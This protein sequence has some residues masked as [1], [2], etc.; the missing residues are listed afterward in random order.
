MKRRTK[1]T[2]II[3][4]LLFCC[5]LSFFFIWSPKTTTITAKPA[6]IV[7]P[8]SPEDIRIEEMH[9]KVFRQLGGY[10]GTEA[11]YAC[12]QKEYKDVSNSYHVHQGRITQDGNI[13]YDPSEAIDVGMGTRWYPFA[14]LDRTV[15]PETHW[16]LME[17]VFCAQCHPGGNVLTQYGMDVDCLIC[18][19]KSGYRGGQGLG[20]SLAGIDRDGN[21]MMSDGG[22][23]VA[24]MMDGAEAGGDMKKLDLSDIAIKAMEGV[25]LRIGKPGP[26][27]CNFCHWRTNSKRG[28][29]YGLFKGKTTDVHYAAGMRCQEC[30]VT[31]DHQI[32]KGKILDAI[33]TPELRGTM[34][35]CGDCHGEEPHMGEYADIMNYHFSRIACETCHIT[36]TYPSA[37]RLNW[38]PGMDIEGM[39][40][41]SS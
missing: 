38:L 23:L 29:R 41:T 19:Q 20:L 33:G 9:S 5:L 22:R 21:M 30:H 2:I 16:K 35:T 17:S 7:F 12:H 11:C 39:M 25:E 8:E 14:N 13:A 40:K 27:N 4:I 1:Y 24:L 3:M 31:T 32:G 37:K 15:E 26:D 6:P 10:K 18:H 36:T 28:T 34:M